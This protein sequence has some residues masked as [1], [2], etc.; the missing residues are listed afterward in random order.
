MDMVMEANLMKNFSI[1]PSIPISLLRQYIFCPR[2]PYFSEL[3]GYKMQAPIW[4]EQGQDFHLDME[5]LILRRIPT[6]YGMTN[7]K[8]QKRVNVISEKLELHGIVDF[9]FYN[10]KYVVPV[11]FKI[12]GIKPSKGQELQ[13]LAYGYA[14]EE[15]KGLTFERGYFVMGSNKKP[16]PVFPS[17][18][19]F[20]EVL[21]IKKLIIGD[22]ATMLMPE[23]SASI[24]KCTQCEY[25]NLCN[26]RNF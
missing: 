20:N 13:L 26:D 21:S 2:I 11:E 5:K 19:K 23:S 8:T 18:S 16:F 6:K 24:S 22:Q 9:I 25:L 4:T 17:E 12:S 1:S 14:L 15:M 3:L 10:D 7:P